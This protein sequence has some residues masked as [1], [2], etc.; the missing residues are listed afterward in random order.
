M[1]VTCITLKTMVPGKIAEFLPTCTRTPSCDLRFASPDVLYQMS[2]IT[3]STRD[4]MLRGRRADKEINSGGAVGLQQSNL[5]AFQNSKSDNLLILEDDCI[6]TRDPQKELQALL[7]NT[8]HFDVAIFGAKVDPL[9]GLE[10]VTFL[11]GWVFLDSKTYLL[12]Y[13]HCVFYTKKAKT[14]LKKLYKEP[15]ETHIDAS[16]K[17]L[18]NTGELRVIVQANHH[19]AVQNSEPSQIIHTK[20]NC[21]QTCLTVHAYILLLIG[22]SFYFFLLAAG[23][24]NWARE[25]AKSV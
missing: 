1:D 7:A 21:S 12:F 9:V 3:L 24:G 11:P 2:L 19:T 5:I 4:T 13:T 17:N 14:L 6:F 15:Q 20:L 25:L 16:L 23:L 8:L 18:N 10:P 22:I